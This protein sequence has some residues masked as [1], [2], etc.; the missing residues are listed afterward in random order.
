MAVGAPTDEV[1][2]RQGRWVPQWWSRSGRWAYA[3]LPPVCTLAIT[4]WGLGAVPLWLDEL[5]T[6]D[7]L[8]KGSSSALALDSQHLP[9]YAWMELWSAGGGAGSD[10][11]L[12]LPSAVFMAIASLLVAVTANQVAGRRAGLAAGL[13]FAVVPG[14]SRF[15]QEA[16]SPAMI[17]ALA[18]GSTLV[19]VLALRKPTA[20]RPW[21]S[22]WALLVPLGLLN[23]VTIALVAGHAVI[24]AREVR[25]LRASRPW[26]AAASLGVLPGVIFGLYNARL[27]S[28]ISWIPRP[29]VHDAAQQLVSLPVSAGFWAAVPLAVGAALVALALTDRT[30]TWWLVAY[31]VPVGLVWLASFGPTSL[32]L[33]RYLVPF[34]PLLAVAAG[35]A[36]RRASPL[37]IV[38]MT[39]VLF[40]IALPALVEARQPGSRG[41]DVAPDYRAAAAILVAEAQPGDTFLGAGHWLDHYQGLGVSRYLPRGT[42]L[43][44]TS[45]VGPRVWSIGDAHACSV[46]RI[47]A[48]PGAPLRL[49]ETP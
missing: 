19:L 28:F 17:T 6:L 49:C 32:W 48:L 4:L 46:E 27:V 3:L 5:V 34:S 25:S 16:R 35:T 2:P 39:S 38:S 7:T 30:G 11:W 8:Q 26:L 1:G 20:W 43:P 31:G 21:I 14:V 12:R 33:A 9:F 10:G 45:D 37:R 42:M 36:L 47:W 40:L 18:A 13:L 29:T 15:G 41:D 24:V 44:V 22:Y 23:P